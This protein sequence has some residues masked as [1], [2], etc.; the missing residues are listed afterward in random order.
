MQQ[1]GQNYPRTED[2]VIQNKQIIFLF[3]ESWALP[4]KMILIHIISR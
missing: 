4:F 2:H 1:H 3:I